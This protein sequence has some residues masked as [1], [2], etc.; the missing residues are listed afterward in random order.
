MKTASYDERFNH[1][2]GDWRRR[3]FTLV[4]LLV[5]VA[6][7]ILL[8]AVAFPLLSKMR[9]A[10]DSANCMSN[11]R[12]VGIAITMY[13]GDNGGQLPALQPELDERTGKRPPIWPVTVADA[14]YMWNGEG[15][16]PCGTGTWTCPNCDFMSNAYGGYGVVE[17]T[18]FVYGEK[19]PVGV[20]QRGSLRLSQIARP[21]STWLVGDT[22]RSADE[23]NKGWYAIWS[24]PKRWNGHSPAPRHNGKVNVC[25]V[26]GH[27]EALTLQ[28]IEDKRL[29]REVV[30]DD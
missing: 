1:S 2:S 4:E 30:K 14:G 22:T 5:V 21:G 11:V 29:T 8:A 12:Q 27:V 19:F 20:K 16:L 3:G 10:A 17:D 18:I 25:M 24:Q 9:S 23:P 26:D 13:A 15:T 28:E 6:I 7:I